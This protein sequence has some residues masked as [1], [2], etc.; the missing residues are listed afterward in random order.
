M[1]VVPGGNR[2]LEPLQVSL[3]LTAAAVAITGGSLLFENG[4]GYLPS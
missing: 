4:L 1:P 2:I 3:S